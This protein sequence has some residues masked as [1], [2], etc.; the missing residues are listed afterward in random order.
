MTANT[1]GPT[2]EQVNGLV[3][4]Q[5]TQKVI[6]QTNEQPNTDIKLNVDA[7]RLGPTELCYKLIGECYADGMMEGEAMY[8]RKE[9]SFN[10]V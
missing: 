1:N 6:E 10:L 3:S 5:A 7:M 9:Q 4:A 8:L 2:S